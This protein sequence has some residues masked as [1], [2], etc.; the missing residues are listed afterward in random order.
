MIGKFKYEVLLEERDFVSMGS[1][2]AR[3]E[4][5]SDLRDANF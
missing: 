1:S 3:K 2:L 4:D 5:D